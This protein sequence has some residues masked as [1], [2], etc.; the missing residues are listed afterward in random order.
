[1]SVWPIPISA[2]AVRRSPVTRRRGLGGRPGCSRAGLFAWAYPGAGSGVFVAV[3]LVAAHGLEL[4]P[5]ALLVAGV[6]LAA[7]TL[8]YA[9][10]MSMFPDAGGS[11]A[12]ARHAFDE[13]ASFLTGWAACLGLAAA[14]AVAALFSAH[15]LSVFWSPLAAGWWA[16]AAAAVVLCAVSVAAIL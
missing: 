10:G 9:E 14:A 12:L 7:A 16:A 5:V 11:A 2:S 4:T 15:Y 6:A 1:M 8:A 3:G 13:L